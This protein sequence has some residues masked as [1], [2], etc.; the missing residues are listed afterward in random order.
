VRQ[1][2][3][4][5]IQELRPEPEDLSRQVAGLL[6]DASREHWPQAWPTRAAALQEVLDSFGPERISRV[7]LAPDGT[8]VGWIAGQEQYDGHAWELHPLVVQP[9]HQLQGIGTALVKDFETQVRARGAT[10][11]WLGTDDEHNLT[12]LGGTDLYPDVLEK[13]STIRNLRSHPYEFYLK[14]GYVIVG[15]LPDA[16]G[17]GKP[18]ILMAKRVGSFQPERNDRQLHG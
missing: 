16:N 10:T 14:L 5:E 15:I 17:P 12:S 2:T 3:L 8:A 7:A 11:I 6:L 13:A 4:V 1:P 18:D 9:G